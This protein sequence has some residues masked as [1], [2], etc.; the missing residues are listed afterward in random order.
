MP[1]DVLI[2]NTAVMDMWSRDFE[3]TRAHVEPGGVA[4][5]SYADMPDFP[6]EQIRDWIETGP[7]CAGGI[8]N[9]APLMSRAGLSVAA[10]ANLGA[11]P[12]GGLDAAGLAFYNILEASGIDLSA[13]YRHPDL[14]TGV[15]FIHDAPDDERGGI[16]YFAN[17]NDDFD[18][19]RYRPH[20]ER[21]SPTVVYYMYSGLSTRA[22]ANGGRDLAGF[23]AWCRSQGC[24]TIVDSHT[25]T[26]NPAELIA[27]GSPVEEYRLLE[28]LLPEL[29]LFFTSSD[30][31]KMI[32][33]TLCEPRDWA[34]IP[35]EEA[36]AL[37]LDFVTS[38]YAG[39]SW[40]QLF[41]VT[42]GSGAMAGL[43]TGQG[44]VRGPHVVE[45]RFLLG[46]AVALT[47]AGDSFRAGLVSYVARNESSFRDGSLNV[48]EALQVGNLAACLYL[49]AP[50]DD[51]YANVRSFEAMLRVVQSPDEFASLKDLMLS[52]DT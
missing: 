14:P 11:G 5:G 36:L 49:T 4:K 28:P 46:D 33:N 31:A 6:Q 52:L 25:L 21:L 26:A 42:Y 20:V 27:S 32:Y 16:V 2:L 50:L 1:V 22:D 3:F 37:Y 38:R 18:F 39:G 44:E 34:A 29:D 12:G 15:T 19:D 47:G 41:G 10:G 35:E 30:E 24:V 43:V 51:R 9:S 45:S 8:G 23:I 7:S 48:P 13:V 40:P 17:A